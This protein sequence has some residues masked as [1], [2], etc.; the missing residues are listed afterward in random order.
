M[1]ALIIIQVLT[2]ALS[3]ITSNP[4][5]CNVGTLC[6]LTTLNQLIKNFDIN[7]CLLDFTYTYLLTYLLTYVMEQNSS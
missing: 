5:Q 2:K 6:L 1:T 4:C 7:G 3:K